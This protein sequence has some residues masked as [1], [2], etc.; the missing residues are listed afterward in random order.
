MRPDGQQATRTA[1]AV[2]DPLVGRGTRPRDASRPLE[3]ST[4]SAFVRDAA[5]HA[6]SETLDD[7][8]PDD[9]RD[10]RR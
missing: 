2:G 5:A 3:L 1:T 6:A 7:D 9:E 8:E 10:P 4:V